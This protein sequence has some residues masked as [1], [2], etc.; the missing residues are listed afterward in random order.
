[1]SLLGDAAVLS[2]AHSL[3]D[4][5]M[6]KLVSL[7][8]HPQAALCHAVPSQSPWGSTAPLVTFL[9]FF[10]FSITPDVVTLKKKRSQDNQDPTINAS[11][12][13]WK[14]GLLVLAKSLDLSECDYDDEFLPSRTTKRKKKLPHIPDQALTTANINFSLFHHNDQRF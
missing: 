5:A 14:P 1:M 7:A 4:R 8:A 11:R 2:G 12:P 9:T 13:R 3:T 10:M 6:N